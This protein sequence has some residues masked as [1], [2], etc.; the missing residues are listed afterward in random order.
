MASR[1]E[2]LRAAYRPDP[3]KVLFV[4]ES[5]PAG[6]RFFYAANSQVHRYLGEALAPYLGDNDFL[7]RFADAGF[8]LDDLVLTPVNHL[9]PRDRAARNLAAIP[10]LAARL[11]TY[12]PQAVVGIAKTIS[13]P[14]TQAHAQ[15]GLDCP[16]HVVAF[17]GTGQQANFRRE[18]TAILPGLLA[19]ART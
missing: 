16:L 8:F 14:L 19:L 1:A 4:G 9:S 3:I 7:N 17:P 5:A 12:Q 6:G 2:A 18:L 15:A 13:E 10:S 11:A